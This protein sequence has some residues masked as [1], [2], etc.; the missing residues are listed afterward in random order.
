MFVRAR[1]AERTGTEYI[2][3][4][5]PAWRASAHME[6]PWQAACAGGWSEASA[7]PHPRD[8]P[9]MPSRCSATPPCLHRPGRKWHA[10]AAC[11]SRSGLRRR[12][13]HRCRA[14]GR[15]APRTQR[16]SGPRSTPWRLRPPSPAWCGCVGRTEGRGRKAADS[17]CRTVAR[18]RCRRGGA[19]GLRGCWTVDR[20][21]QSRVVLVGRRAPV[22]QPEVALRGGFLRWA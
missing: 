20:I 7:P 12:C 3:A 2:L 5:A 18:G 9:R 21:H 11:P 17:W 6:R 15:A 14:A 16:D 22:L 19:A 1:L 13:F 8:S 10:V 4:A